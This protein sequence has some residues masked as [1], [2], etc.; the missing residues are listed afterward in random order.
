MSLD[1]II[2]QRQVGRT[3]STR[4]YLSQTFGDVAVMFLLKQNH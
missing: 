2:L 4:L 3:E 1:Y